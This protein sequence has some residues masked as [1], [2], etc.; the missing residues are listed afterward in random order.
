MA[1]FLESQPEIRDLSLR[2]IPSYTTDPFTLKRSTLPHLEN[3]RSVQLDPDTL[4]E[5][6]A[7]LADPIFC[8]I[9]IEGW[10]NLGGGDAAG[11]GHL[12]L[13]ILRTWLS[14]IRSARSDLDTRP[15]PNNPYRRR[16]ST[17][18]ALPAARRVLTTPRI[19][20]HRR[21]RTRVQP[22]VYD[23][24]QE[25]TPLLISER[26]GHV[27]RIRSAARGILWITL[28]HVHG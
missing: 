10:V 26:P 27:A 19:T 28:S 23:P 4:G 7:Y 25:D 13:L 22:R 18:R 5:V 3:F 11:A 12:S 6:G 1:A 15:A 16:V 2:G 20:T 9:G 24:Y 8:Q 21:P 17:K 14:R